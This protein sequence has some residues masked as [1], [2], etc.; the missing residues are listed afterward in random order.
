M[1]AVVVIDVNLGHAIVKCVHASRCDG[2]SDCQGCLRYEDH[3][4]SPMS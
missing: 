1:G 4:R 3:D 2:S